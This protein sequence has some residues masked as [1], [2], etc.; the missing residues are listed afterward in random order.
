MTAA[1]VVVATGA[2]GS[3]GVAVAEAVGLAVTDGFSAAL[4]GALA[5]AAVGVRT[6]LLFTESAAPAVESAGVIG[7]SVPVAAGCCIVFAAGASSNAPEDT[8]SGATELSITA[9]VGDPKRVTACFVAV[10]FA[11]CVVTVVADFAGA[12]TADPVVVTGVCTLAGADV[13]VFMVAGSPSLKVA[14]AA[15]AG[16]V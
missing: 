9:G 13:F 11:G 15:L 6:V 5:S 14:L 3:V 1:P 2:A 4:R 8:V 7:V 12:T 16:V 10:G